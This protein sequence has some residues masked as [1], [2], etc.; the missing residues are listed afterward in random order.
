MTTAR[1]SA[2]AKLAQA[3]ILRRREL[4]P[5]HWLVCIEKPE[6]YTYK[7]VQY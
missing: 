5:D 4:T 6:G 7:P 1:H 3:R 2:R